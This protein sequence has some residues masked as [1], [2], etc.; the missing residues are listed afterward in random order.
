[1]RKFLTGSVISVMSLMAVSCA[2]DSDGEKSASHLVESEKKSVEVRQPWGSNDDPQKLVMDGTF[3]YKF[4]DLPLE[5]EADIVPWAGSYWPTHEDSINYK[6]NGADSMSAS[7]KY[8]RA[9]DKTEIE[10]KVSN[11]YGVAKYT[12][13]KACTED[14]ECDDEACAIRDGEDS[15]FCIPTWWGIC[16]AWA[17]AA[18]D[19]PEPIRPV[20]VTNDAGEEIEF[21]VNDIKALVTYSYNKGK[22][23]KFMS[24]RCNDKGSDIE[25]DEYGRP[26]S[27]KCNDT[28]AGSFHVVATNLLGIQ[29][30]SFVEDRTYDFE[31]W[32]Q[33]V[34]GYSATSDDV[35]GKEANELL[36]VMGEVKTTANEEGSIAKEAWE[37]FAAYDVVEGDKI[38]V[39]MTGTG[40]ADL[41]VRLGS[42]PT[43]G[44]HD[45]R[46][47]ANGSNETCTVDVPAGT[48]KVFV[49][50]NGYAD[51]S[52]YKVNI[53]IGGTTP[54]EYV[55]N[56]DAV[57][58]KYVM[59]AF[60]YITESAASLDG[61]LSSSID[62]YTR[63]DN[64]E[65]ILEIDAEG[66]II[67]GE[68]VGASKKNHPDFLWYTYNKTNYTV[69]GIEWNDIKEIL[70]LSTEDE[71]TEPNPG[72]ECPATMETVT[73]SD[74]VA[75]DAWK[76]YGPFTA[77]DGEFK[78]L[79][80]G[81]GD[82]DLYVKKG[83]QPTSS[84]HD[85]RPYKSG[86]SEVC[87]LN[88][89]GEYYV[90]VN[91]YAASSDFNLDITFSKAAEDC[92]TEEPVDPTEPVLATVNESGTVSKDAWKH[93]G[94]FTATDGEFKALMTGSGDADLYVK[95]GSQ[96]TSSS[97]D[98]R[99]YDG[100]SNENCNL[101]DGAG[102]YFV[103]VKGYA[104]TSDFNLEISYMKAQ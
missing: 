71:T 30:K 4:A 68:W 42:Q 95:K 63:T 16:H 32:N 34:R 97:Y 101:N 102:E 93:F 21:K 85:C 92:G 90:S 45:C 54:E 62:T 38:T 40:D 72:E 98:C 36:G 48:D 43:S 5:G 2:N 46:P 24:L 22:S 1:M 87:N 86:S 52:D 94:P 29:K 41:Y 7:L 13:R 77:T 17:P 91:G 79:M 33:P 57:S 66:K 37:H 10:D 3:N 64:Y 28:N 12:S 88:G 27:T 8:E 50:L 49:S 80:T 89:S 58:F 75:K 84:N 103:S 31:V 56:D 65:Y 70:R 19:Q 67:G 51:S 96:P 73:D 20:T 78:A 15:G 53:T 11:D 25:L 83:S 44:A 35:T 39:N 76:H 82:A 14:S 9:F 100:G 69:S 61:N 18:V 60:Q 104:A 26:E 55:F 47:Y 81:S 23:T 74:T 99:P 6:W 59:M